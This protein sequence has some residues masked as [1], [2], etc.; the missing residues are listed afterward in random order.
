MRAPRVKTRVT[1]KH[2]KKRT[3]YSLDLPNEEELDNLD[4]EVDL[5][6][7]GSFFIPLVDNDYYQDDAEASRAVDVEVIILSSDSEPV[8]TRKIR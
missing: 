3:T 2:A 4:L 7:L 5:D 1:K 8:P 6:S